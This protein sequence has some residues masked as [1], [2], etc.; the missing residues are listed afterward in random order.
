MLRDPGVERRLDKPLFR[1]LSSWFSVKHESR[2]MIR[3]LTIPNIL[4][5]VRSLFQ[6]SLLQ[7][8]LA[9]DAM[10]R[11]GHS[12][13]AFGV[14]LFAAG[15]AFTKLAFAQA[16]QSAIH[17]LKKLAVVVALVK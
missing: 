17:H 5:L 3:R 14:D 4:A 11:P 10:P 6:N 8:F 1:I 12:L 13:E 2:R 7:F 15:D 16:L 9:F